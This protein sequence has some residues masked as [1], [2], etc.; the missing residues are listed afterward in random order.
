MADLEKMILAKRSNALAGF[1]DNLEKKYCNDDKI[2]EDE[3]G[4][5]DDE[6][7]KKRKQTTKPSQPKK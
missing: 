2:V 3:N 7:P 1:L 6:A 5:I 4:W